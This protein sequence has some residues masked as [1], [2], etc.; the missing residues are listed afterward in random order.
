MTEKPFYMNRREAIR[1]LAEMED[2]SKKSA[3]MIR[4]AIRAA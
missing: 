4:L 3:H 1:D 2:S